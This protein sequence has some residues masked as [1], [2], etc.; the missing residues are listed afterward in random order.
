MKSKIKIGLDGIV[1]PCLIYVGASFFVSTVFM[2]AFKDNK[3]NLVLLQGISNLIVL[4]I[5]IPLYK[6]F[7]TNY[8]IRYSKFEVSKVYYLVPL[9]LSICII[10]NLIASY[11]PKAGENAVSREVGKLIQEYN[12]YVALVAIAIIVPIV[13]EIIFRGFFFETIK[14]LTNNVIAIVLSSLI[15]AIAHGNI[16]Q[17]VYAAFAGIFLAYIKYKYESIKYTIIMHLLMNL[18]T[19]V[20]VP[21]V[22]AIKDFKSQLFVIF[23]SVCILLLTLIRINVKKDEFGGSK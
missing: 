10:S 8:K 22:L 23:I 19:L 16:E 13:E 4:F 9:S 3:F 6:M 12:I 2:L 1:I 21:D 14:Y 7:V 17:G 11:I 5:F 20:I 15:F 18:T